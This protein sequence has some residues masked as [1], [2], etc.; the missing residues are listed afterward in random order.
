MT[1]KVQSEISLLVYFITF[2]ILYIVDF[3]IFFRLHNNII[4]QFTSA[5]PIHVRIIYFGLGP[6]LDAI[7]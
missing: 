6:S 2:I 1:N 5:C 3:F 7:Q 4:Q